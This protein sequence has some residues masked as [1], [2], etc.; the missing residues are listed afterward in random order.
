M[1]RY[2]IRRLLQGIVIIF[3]ITVV[4]YA[5]IAASTDPMAQYTNNKN[6]SAADRA[7]IRHDLG[8]DQPVYMQ[9]AAWL[10]KALRGD[11]GISSVTKEPVGAMIWDRLPKTLALM[12]V[13]EIVII[14]LSLALGVFSAVKKYSLGDNVVT[15]FSF[16]GF[17]M[18][19]FFVGLALIYIFAVQFKAWG[20][21]YL[22][23]GTAMWNQNDPV[24]WAR[25]L[26]LPVTTIAIISVAGYTRYLR[27][28]ML[29]TMNQDYVRTARS[30]GISERNVLW[31]HA[32]KNA[33]LPFITIIALDIPVLFAGALVTETVFTWPG[34]GRLFWENADKGDFNVMMGILLIA[35]IL[36]VIGQIIVDVGYTFLDPRI[37]L[38]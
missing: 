28:S 18:P 17:S 31:G 27:S 9:Y 7:R 35:A 32:L 8:L 21:P 6:I 11:L 19:V 14:V 29:E 33:M 3:I 10:G 1:S 4:S 26:I 22:P 20:L 30:K 25:H 38:A 5:I 24:E 16:I 13:A 2:L 12:V 15:A 34:M 36:V 37:K 23:T